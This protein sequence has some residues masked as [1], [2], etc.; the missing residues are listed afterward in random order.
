M[1]WKVEV[2][3]LIGK[4]WPCLSHWFYSFD[5]H[6]LKIFDKSFIWCC[7]KIYKSRMS[8][9]IKWN[10]IQL[11]KLLIIIKWTEI[12]TLS[13]QSFKVNMCTEKYLSLMFIASEL[14]LAESFYLKLLIIFVE[15]LRNYII[16]SLGTG[17]WYNLLPCQ[18]PFLIPKTYSII[19]R[20]L[21]NL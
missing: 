16:L 9:R 19:T 8:L 6:V 17:K 2:F 21:G 20:L 5:L 12:G 10:K 4:H 13:S 1:Y 3:Y 15:F 14:K 7:R 11:V 18:Y